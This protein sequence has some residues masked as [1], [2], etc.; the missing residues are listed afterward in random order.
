[1]KRFKLVREV[2]DNMLFLITVMDEEETN[3]DNSVEHYDDH[4]AGTGSLVRRGL[5]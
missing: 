4:M 3:T 5:E 1:M 2:E